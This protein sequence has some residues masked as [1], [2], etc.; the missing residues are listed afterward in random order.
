MPH[1]LKLVPTGDTIQT[2]GWPMKSILAKWGKIDKLQHFM[3]IISFAN[4]L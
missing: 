3:L 2:P 4:F 1:Y